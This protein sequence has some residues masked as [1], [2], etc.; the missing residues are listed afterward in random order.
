SVVRS[1]MN[2][3][4]LSVTTTG[5]TT[6]SLESVRNE[7]S[8]ARAALPARQT[9]SSA[10]R[11]GAMPPSFCLA[12]RA[13][14]TRAEPRA[15]RPYRYAASEGQAAQDLEQRQLAPGAWQMPA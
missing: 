9:D 1:E 4:C 5:S 6:S 11:T 3:P 13:L 8:C 14:S 15:E 10:K 12:I 7:G 2:R